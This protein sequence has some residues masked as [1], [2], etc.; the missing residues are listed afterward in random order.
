MFSPAEVVPYPARIAKL[1]INFFPN[2]RALRRVNSNFPTMLEWRGFNFKD[3]SI[4][5][6]PAGKPAGAFHGVLLHGRPMLD[7]N[8]MARPALARKVGVF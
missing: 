7:L 6:G 8:R 1:P 4:H 2:D 3:L 5:S